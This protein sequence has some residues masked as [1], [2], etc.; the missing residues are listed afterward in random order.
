MSTGPPYL[1][2]LV[3][4]DQHISHARCASLPVTAPA[5]LDLVERTERVS[6]APTAITNMLAL[7]CYPPEV[8]HALTP[9]LVDIF[10]AL[11]LTSVL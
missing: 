11:T 1:R 7:M 3:A 2:L 5:L 4:G 8:T 9:L 6:V 10:E